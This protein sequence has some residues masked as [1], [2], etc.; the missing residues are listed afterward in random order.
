MQTKAKI[1]KIPSNYL[2]E[3]ITY[4]SRKNVK[5]MSDILK[6]EHQYI[7]DKKLKKTRKNNI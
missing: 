6:N 7:T 4:K 2:P 1:I 5:N 3:N